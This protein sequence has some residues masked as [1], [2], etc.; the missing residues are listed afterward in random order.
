MPKLYF[1]DDEPAIRDSLEQAM[2]IEGIDIVCFPNAIEALKQINKI[3]RER[4][5]QEKIA[6]KLAYKV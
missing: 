1:V 4:L 2:L 3:D 6:K 5:K